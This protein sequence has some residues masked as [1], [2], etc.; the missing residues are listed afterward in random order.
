MAEEI[1][2]DGVSN[3]EF[4]T[5]NFPFEDVRIHV[6]GVKVTHNPRLAISNHWGE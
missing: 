2:L 1:L 6:G 4:I 5:S 3:Q